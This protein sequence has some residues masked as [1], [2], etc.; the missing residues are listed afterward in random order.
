M[1]GV[2]LIYLHSPSGAA[3]PRDHAYI[4]V[5]PLPAVLQP[6]NVMYCVIVIIQSVCGIVYEV[7]T[8]RVLIFLSH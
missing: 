1:L 8:I 4:S 6:I 3:H 7:C 5:K 2:L